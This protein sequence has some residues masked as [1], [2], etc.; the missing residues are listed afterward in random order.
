MQDGQKTSVRLSRMPQGIRF[1]GT[2]D[3]RI[4]YDA[5]R[6]LLVFRGVMEEGVRGQLLDLSPERTYRDSAD[7]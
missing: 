1:T 2:L 4:R 7:L 6:Q 3:G 5:Q